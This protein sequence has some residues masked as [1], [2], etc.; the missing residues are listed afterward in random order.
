MDPKRASTVPNGR[1]RGPAWAYELPG[2]GDRFGDYVVHEALGQG[3]MGTVF[4]ARDAVLER[5]VALKLIHPSLVG[6]EDF[7]GMFLGEARCMASIAH[8]NVVQV[9]ALGNHQEVP[10][11]AM[12]LLSGGSVQERI[13][14][15]GPLELDEALPIL[16]DVAEGLSAIHRAGRVHGD[17]KPA[18]VLLTEEGD[19][20]AL[21]DM[22][23]SFTVG[24]DDGAL[25]G[26]PAY[27]APERTTSAPVPAELQPRADVYGLALLAF[28]MLTGRLPFEADLT[29]EMLDQ[30]AMAEVPR[31]S[32]L[33]DFVDPRVDEPLLR[34]LRKDPLE[35]TATPLE[36]VEQLEEAAELESDGEEL[37]FLVVDDD[38]DWRTMLCRVLE[39]RFPFATVEQASDGAAGV[40]AALAAPPDVAL[41]DL[42]MPGLDGKDLT[43]VLRELAPA[44]RMPIVVLSGEGGAR[45]WQA[46][47]ELGADRFF[48]K[49]CPFD[50]LCDSIERLVGWR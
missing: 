38:D 10:F 27:L 1:H 34:A 19:R 3:G 22:G 39:S 15:E 31:P 17:V 8:P 40:A 44:E 11:I 18:N 49:P 46:L 26:T 4:R 12:E 43:G 45:D 41:L 2:E 32:S 13:L 47:R 36:L 14:A 35:R 23:V 20:A 16:R 29:A 6:R 9:F 25:R 24:A 37:R 28:E 21:T 50:E 33:D 7:R 5:D 30:H 42:N 48:V